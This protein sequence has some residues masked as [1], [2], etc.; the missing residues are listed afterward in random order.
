MTP[1]I[2]AGSTCLSAA[3]WRMMSSWR[4]GSWISSTA[5]STGRTRLSTATI[6]AARPATS[7]SRRLSSWRRR[8]R[9]RAERARLPERAVAGWALI[10]GRQLRKNRRQ[11]L[12]Q[13]AQAAGV[14]YSVGGPLGLLGLRELA[15]GALVDRLVAARG[16]PFGP[17]RLIRHDGDRGVVARLQPGLE[18]QRRLH[19]E[20]AGR[21]LAGGVG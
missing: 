20:R 17:H 13:F 7:T 6:T 2:S 18:Q 11:L 3:C 16:G 8:A 9:A 4:S 10:S 19:H 15:R 14:F 21:A 5:W 12:L 1:A